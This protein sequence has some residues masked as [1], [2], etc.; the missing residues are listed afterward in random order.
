MS[1][2]GALGLIAGSF[3]A[4]LVVRWPRGETIAAGRSACD[5]CGRRLHV[6]ELIP[7]ASWLWS[8]GRCQSCGVPIDQA[9]PVVEGLCA[10]IGAA[11]FAVAPGVA[12]LIGALFGWIL[13]A[14]AA[15]DLR[16]FWLPDRLVFAVF[17]LSIASWWLGLAPAGPDRFVGALG[18]YATLAAV[19]SSYRYLR[20]R[21]GLGAG[22][23][24]LFGAL[25]A[26]LGW[27]LLPLVLV[28][29]CTVGLLYVAARFARG[30]KVGLT[31]RLPLG[32]LLAFAAFP[33]W[34]FLQ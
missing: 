25:G 33:A 15:L 27:Q 28:G 6:A 4:T 12:G 7:I 18:G 11:S 5:N 17:L 14:L 34:I 2:G 29:A 23:A 10:L 32:A 26:M 22:D 31:D 13:V 16:H 1:V 19:A 9:H 3:L 21:D 8:R 24:K 20:K 30:N